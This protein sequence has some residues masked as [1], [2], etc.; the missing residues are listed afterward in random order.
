MV[1]SF[2]LLYS[3]RALF[4]KTNSSWLMNESIK[5]LEIKTSMSFNLDF[6]NRTILSCFFFFFLNIDLYFFIPAVL[7]QMFSQIA[8]LVIPIEIPSK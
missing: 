1:S 7:A 6:D 3:F 8:E 5:A 2:I 4:I